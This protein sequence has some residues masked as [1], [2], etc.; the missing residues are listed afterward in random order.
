MLKEALATFSN[1]QK[2]FKSLTEGKNSTQ[3]QINGSLYYQY[4][5]MNKKQKKTKTKE[6]KHNM[7]VYCLCDVTEGGED[8]AL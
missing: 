8:S 1:P 6:E 4:A 2:T 5:Q 7:S 3:C